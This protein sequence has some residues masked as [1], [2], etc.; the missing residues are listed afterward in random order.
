M[1]TIKTIFKTFAIETKFKTDCYVTK[2]EK[3]KLSFYS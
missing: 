2:K 3:P 1:I